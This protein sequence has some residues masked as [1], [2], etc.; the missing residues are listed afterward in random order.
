VLCIVSLTP[1]ATLYSSPSLPEPYKLQSTG[2]FPSSFKASF[3]REK[4]LEPMKGTG[5]LLAESGE[6]WFEVMTRC[7]LLL[8]DLPFSCRG[9]AHS[10]HGGPPKG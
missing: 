4:H 2:C 9:P 3:A 10:Q 1:P 5:G 8:M 7:L 6:G